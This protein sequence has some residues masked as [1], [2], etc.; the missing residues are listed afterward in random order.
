MKIP[1]LRGEKKMFWAFSSASFDT[2]T[3]INFLKE[4]INK[5]KSGTIFTLTGNVWGYDISLF[6]VWVKK[7]YY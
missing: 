6:N 4:D 2:Q 1:Y 3:A 5:N 7:K